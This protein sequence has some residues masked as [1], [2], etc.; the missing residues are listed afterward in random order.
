MNFRL[1]KITQ[2]LTIDENLE[3]CWSVVTL[4]DG[5]WELEKRK[6][7]QYI[8]EETQTVWGKIV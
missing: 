6:A 3:Q 8:V 5:A 1:L 4:A 7:N 2:F